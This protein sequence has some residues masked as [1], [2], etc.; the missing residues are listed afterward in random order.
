MEFKLENDYKKFQSE[1]DKK[2]VEKKS[3]EFLS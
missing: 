1:H 3:D 2:K